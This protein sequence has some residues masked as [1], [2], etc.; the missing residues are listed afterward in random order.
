MRSLLGRGGLVGRPHR[1][2]LP[3]PKNRCCF[4]GVCGILRA[5]RFLLAPCRALTTW[6]SLVLGLEGAVTLGCPAPV[7]RTAQLRSPVPTRGSRTGPE[8]WQSASTDLHGSTRARSC[9]TSAR[10]K[11]RRLRT[12][13]SIPTAWRHLYY[14]RARWE[15]RSPVPLILLEAALVW[16]GHRYPFR[17]RERRVRR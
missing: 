5:F 8:L 17:P 9:A 13:V 7:K 4:G 16:Q 1:L 11:R 12:H 3:R 15:S 10:F 2:L 6:K 14:R